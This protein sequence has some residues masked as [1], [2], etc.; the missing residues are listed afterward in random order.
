MN[1]HLASSV[2][3]GTRLVVA[4]APGFTIDEAR[5]PGGE[6]PVALGRE[7]AREALQVSL[8]GCD[9]LLIEEEW[10]RKLARAA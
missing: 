4:M 3:P 9:E 8:R 6:Q 5:P 10:L 7:Q 2:A 1:F